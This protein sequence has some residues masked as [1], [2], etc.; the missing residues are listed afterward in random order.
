[1]KASC[2]ILLLAVAAANI[3]STSSTV[4]AKG[5]SQRTCLPALRALM[6]HSLW[7]W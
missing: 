7:R 5:F 4:K 2:K 6:D 3:S 1:M